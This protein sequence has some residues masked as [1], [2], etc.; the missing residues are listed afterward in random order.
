[1]LASLFIP[2]VSLSDAIA[3]SN[4]MEELLGIRYPPAGLDT[5]G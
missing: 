4:L 5:K 3:P 2:Q 1:M